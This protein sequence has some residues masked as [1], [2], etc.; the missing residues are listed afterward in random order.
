MIISEKQILRLIDRTR[1]LGHILMKEGVFK[2][3]VEA[4]SRELREI[5]EQQSTDLTEV[6]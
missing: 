4:I 1:T 5:R 2:E 3:E 6:K